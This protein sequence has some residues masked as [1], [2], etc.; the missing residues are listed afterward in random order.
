VLSPVQRN[1]RR[2][3]GAISALA[4]ALEA[5]Y[6]EGGGELFARVEELVMRTAYRHCDHNQLETARLLGISRNVVRARLIQYGDLRGPLR[7]NHEAGAPTTD[8]PSQPAQ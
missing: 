2:P 1:V 6:E 8:Q 7:P 4:A 5:L 3:A